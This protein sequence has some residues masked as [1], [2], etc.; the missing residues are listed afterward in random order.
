MSGRTRSRP[1]TGPSVK[2]SITNGST[3]KPRPSRWSIAGRAVSGEI[4]R[5]GRV[6]GVGR[7]RLAVRQQHRQV[8]RRRAR[9][10]GHPTAAAT[11]DSRTRRRRHRGDTASPGA[12]RRASRWSSSRRKPEDRAVDGAE[13]IERRSRRDRSRSRT[14]SVVERHRRVDAASKP[15][16]GRRAVETGLEVARDRARIGRR[17]DGP[18]ARAVAR[19]GPREQLASDT[20]GLARGED[21]E[22]GQLANA[23]AH[24]RAGVADASRRSIVLGDP[25]LVAGRGQVVEQ[26]SADVPRRWVA[27][28]GVRVAAGPS[29]RGR[30]LR[31]RRSRKQ[32][33]EIGGV[34]RAG[35]GSCDERSGYGRRAILGRMPDLPRKPRG[36]CRARGPAR[37]DRG[38]PPAASW[39]R[40]PDA[41]AD[42]GER[43]RN[44]S[45]RATGAAVA[46]GRLYLKAE[47]LQKTGSFKARGMTNR[48][49]TLAPTKRG[50]AGAIT[51]SAGNAGQAYAWAGRAAG[52]PMTVVM[53]DGAVRSKVEACLRV[54]RAGRPP[55]RA[56][57]RHVRRDGTDPRRRRS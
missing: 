43:P 3:R 27:G 51:L 35:S 4:E 54:W 19:E 26:G 46:D 39:H 12:A 57:R 7:R 47:H 5:H 22:F 20:A 13:R 8:G 55:W 40:P 52:V 15:I 48:I 45:A 30:R 56:R 11:G 44:G 50:R 2:N 42:V 34:S 33:R 1:S 16:I 18:M 6:A 37:G 53:P 38:T 29:R 14:R 10:T 41:A 23:V 17:D 31:S 9:R 36:R 32:P 28:G 24:D 21:E 25:P 49:A